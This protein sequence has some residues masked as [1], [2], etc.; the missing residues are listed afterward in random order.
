MK[1]ESKLKKAYGVSEAG[2]ADLPKKV[3]GITVS[4]IVHGEESG[5]SYCFPHG[6]ETVN[7]KFGK[8][9]RSW[10]EHRKKQWK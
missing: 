5:C 1:K 8:I 10:K 9:Q 3:S 6:V 2:L 4:R 7:S